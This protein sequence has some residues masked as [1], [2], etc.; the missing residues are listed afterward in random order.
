MADVQEI[1]QAL[2]SGMTTTEIGVS[3]G[4]TG[5]AIRLTLK[6]SGISARALQRERTISKSAKR[7][8]AELQRK[9]ERCQR[10][11]GCDMQSFRAVTGSTELGRVGPIAKAYWKHKDNARRA[12]IPWDISIV[13]Y[14]RIVGPHLN[15]IRRGGLVVARKDKSM[16]VSAENIHVIPHG[17]NSLLTNGFAIGQPLSIKR[18]KEKASIAKAKTLELYE[19]GMSRADICKKLKRSRASIDSYIYQAKNEKQHG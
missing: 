12:K 14:A 17:L 13:D 10:N 6:R 1:L 18:R 15:D 3:R 19:Q 7:Q 9:E 5:Q 11:Y 2:Q 4:V 8:A 16:G